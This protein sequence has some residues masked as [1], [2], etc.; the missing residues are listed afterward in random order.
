MKYLVL[1]ACLASSSSVPQAQEWSRFR[2]PNGSGVSETSKLPA[3]FGPDENFLWKAEVPFG[4]SSPILTEKAVVVTGADE[5]YLFAM[6]FDRKSGEELWVQRLERARAEEVYRANDSASPTPVTD[7][8]SV[9]TFFPELG[10][11][12]FDEHGDESWRLPLGPFVNFYGMSSSPI[13]AGDVLVLLCDQQQG[14]FIIGVDAASGKERWRKERA[15]LIE[16][17]STPVVRPFDAPVE[18]IVFGSY[19]VTSYSVETGEELWRMKGFGYTP[20]CSP[21]LRGDRLFVSVPNH[22]EA[23]IPDWATISGQ[24]DGNGDG[25]IVPTE[26]GGEMGEHFG[27][28]DVDKDEVITEAE[29]NTAYEGM[30]SNGFGLAAIDLSGDEPVELWRYRK[31]L[32]SISS[33]LL[34]EGVIYLA[35]DGGLVT[36]ID[37]KNG[38]VL[39]R[40]RLPD[41]MG[42]C[43][44]S[45]VAA[46]GKIFMA[47]SEGKVAVVAAG[48]E[49][50][51]LQTN[52]IG[53]ECLA[54]P[55]IGGNALYLRTRNTLWSFGE[56]GP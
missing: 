7:G 38:E 35:R 47:N 30:N 25:K 12:A 44:P 43:W 45:P 32:P 3:S 34:Y 52:D 6:A 11:V 29:W 27:W 21:I 19:F 14:S 55:A 9:F 16:C 33:P 37:A 28:V 22:A 20:V 54:S 17:W 1:V 26:M 15:G 13:L 50:K 8:K 31:A 24:V 53:E 36:L 46:D 5:E 2:G 48:A 41:G 39:S 23:G 51:V 42:N 18:V 49:W 56:P 4:S 10:L 40:E